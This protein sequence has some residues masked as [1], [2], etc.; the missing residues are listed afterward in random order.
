[1]TTS[2]QQDAPSAGSNQAEVASEKILL[3][4]DDP[5]IQDPLSLALR[6]EGFEVLQAFD[7]PTGLEMARGQSP[8]LVLLDL[9]LPKM[10]G[11]EVCREIRRFST[12]PILMVTA[13]GEE[14][15]QVV[16]L[17]MGADDYIVKPFGIRQLLARVRANLRRVG[18]SEDGDERQLKDLTVSLS[19]RQVHRGQEPIHLSYREF[20][21][22]RS[23]LEAHGAVVP[24]ERLLAAVWGPDWIGD[25]KT[26]DVHIRWLREKLESEPGHPRL[27][28]TVRGVGYRLAV[29]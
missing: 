5:M 16:G 25:P 28:L 13:R 10:N 9:M 12:V 8:S 11:L 14:S 17:E 21:L 7:G 26:L 20:E 15:D 2:Q 4:E 3:I 1:M 29:D 23:L 22:L 18:Y 27:I 24:R 19:R 6:R